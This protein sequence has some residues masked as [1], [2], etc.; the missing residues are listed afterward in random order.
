MDGV[1]A[2]RFS[3]TAGESLLFQL[4]IIC[5]GGLIFPIKI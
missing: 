1:T 2:L 3:E 4:G 5:M